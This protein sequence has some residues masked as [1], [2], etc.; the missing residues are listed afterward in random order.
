MALRMHAGVVLAARACGACS[1]KCHLLHCPGVFDRSLSHLSPP[2]Q[3]IRALSGPGQEF[4]G[5]TPTQ[6]WTAVC[7]AHRTGQRISG[8][9]Y[10]GF[11]DALT[12]RAIA[13]LY[14]A[15]ELA[16]ALKVVVFRRPAEGWAPWAPMGAGGSTLVSV[17][18][19]PAPPLTPLAALSTHRRARPGR[20]SCA[21]RSVRCVNSWACQ[22]S[23]AA[24][25]Q[26]SP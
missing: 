5:P 10:F 19:S 20:R 26:A 25:P 7:L 12:Q 14:D 18:V 3:Q 21:G 6:P 22:A 17:D 2:Y 8:P 11:S 1:P 23:A 15:R 24:W 13:G 4:E 9:Q 16:A